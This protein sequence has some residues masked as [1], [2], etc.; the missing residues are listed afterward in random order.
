MEGT[1]AQITIAI[2]GFLSKVDFYRDPSSSTNKYLLDLASDQFPFVPDLY[3][4]TSGTTWKAVIAYLNGDPESPE[5]LTNAN[6]W[7]STSSEAIALRYNQC[8]GSFAL[9]TTLLLPDI[10]AAC[11]IGGGLMNAA[12]RFGDIEDNRV[13]VS[14]ASSTG[15]LAL[16]ASDYLTF[17]FYSFYQSGG[18]QQTFKLVAVDKTKQY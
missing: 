14:L 2:P 5:L 1:P 3:W 8:A 9:T 16:A 18:G 15:D 13:R 4:Y 17:A 6:L 11:G 12:L 7:R 10:A